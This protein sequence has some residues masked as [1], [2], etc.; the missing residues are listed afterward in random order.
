MDKFFKNKDVLKSCLVLLFFVLV[1]LVIYF[2][3]LKSAPLWDD[4]F[5]I[6]KSWTLKNI[7]PAQFW[8]WGEYRRS[9]P[10]FYT[11]I[12]YMFK[13]WGLNYLNYHV[14]SVVLHALNSFLIF[15]ILKKMGGNHSFLISFLFL[16]H[17]LHFYSV[18][19]IIQIKTLMSIFFFLI[20][21]D[22]FLKYDNLNSKKSYVLSVAF[23][24]LSLLSKASFAPIVLLMPFYKHRTKMIPYVVICLYAAGLTLWS[25]HIK[26]YTKIVRLPD[27]IISNL[28]AE[29]APAVQVIIPEMRPL[30]PLAP[31]IVIPFKG[32]PL[33]FNNLTK[34]I[35]FTIYPWK[36]LLVHPP[37]IA[38][39]S[40][41]EILLCMLTFF[42]LAWIIM[43]YWEAQKLVPLA[44]LFFFLI[45][46]LP[47]CG[48][49]DIPI[50]H[51]S[52]FVEYWLS[53]PVLGLL[54]CL[55]FIRHYL[56]KYV[57]ITFILVLGVKTY[58]VARINSG[59][60]AMI[61]N[62]S[63]ASP[64]S[65][66]IKLILAS[67]YTYE[68]K[69]SLANKVLLN[70]VKTSKVDK[71]KIEAQMDI[72]VRRMTGEIIDDSTL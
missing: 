65:P 23:F 17:P 54:L 51:Y 16:I 68:K 46:I 1:S 49:I 50:F 58:N 48:A 3:T 15:K 9:W 37:T 12:S 33:M 66:L 25:S 60:V 42:L 29:V 2:P 41:S 44:G 18:V 11:T 10:V 7:S 53:V 72:N 30:L 28:N 52:N 56:M 36:T 31:E 71:E 13:F 34:Y 22:F 47:L 35:A 39:Y 8:K 40:Y 14:V 20:S 59:P 4:W 5:F 43:R 61:T 45:T 19:W 69:Y 70:V 67:H 63:I 26:D 24:A 21:F 64:K 57:L 27:F 32:I 38:K 6:F 55:A 62:S